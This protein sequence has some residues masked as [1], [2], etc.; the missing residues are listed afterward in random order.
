MNC[1]EYIGD[2]RYKCP[3]LGFIVTKEELPLRCNL[4]DVSHQI[5]KMPSLIEQAKN[6]ATSL[7]KHVLNGFQ[8]SSRD[9][10]LQRIEACNQCDSFDPETRRCSEC[11]C[12]VLVKTKWAS[13][14]CPLGKWGNTLE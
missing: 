10:F 4:C 1:L 5:R 11:G 7:A 13:E 12:F 14:E 6:I 8:H 9:E 3:K 2:G